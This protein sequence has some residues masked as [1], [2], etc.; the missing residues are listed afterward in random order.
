M[1]FLFGTAPGLAVFHGFQSR[2]RH[3]PRK[4]RQGQRQAI[5]NPSHYKKNAVR[6]TR[7]GKG[8]G[9]PAQQKP[10][11]RP[12]SVGG[13]GGLCRRFLPFVD[14]V[15]GGGQYVDSVLYTVQT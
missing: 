14:I 2:D 15:S 12:G 8:W 4:P 1:G 9:G 10:G 5:K 11:A 3:N 7:R 13:S 6:I